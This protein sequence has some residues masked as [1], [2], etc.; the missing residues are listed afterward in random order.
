MADGD[1]ASR[2]DRRAVGELGFV[3]G[4]RGS[5]VPLQRQILRPG[6]GDDQGRHPGPA[7]TR[8][9]ART[10]IP[11]PSASSPEQKPRVTARAVQTHL[12]R[13]ARGTL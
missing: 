13:T 9:A 4:G 8:F 2:E 5:F 11:W 12:F 7:V 6:V 10:C 3:A 1:A